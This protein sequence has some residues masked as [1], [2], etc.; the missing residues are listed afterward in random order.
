MLILMIWHFWKVRKVKGVAVPEALD[1]IRI[2]SNPNLI[3][4]ELVVGLVLLAVLF[5]LA[6]LIPAPLLDRANPAYSPNP[7]KAPWYFMGIQELLLHIHPFFAFVVIPMFFF[8][9]LILYPCVI[10][11]GKQ[12]VWFHSEKGKRLRF[13]LFGLR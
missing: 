8:G 1:D 13:S 5:L 2:P 11:S 7:A 6:A 9:G 3:L 10:K 4:K 12:G